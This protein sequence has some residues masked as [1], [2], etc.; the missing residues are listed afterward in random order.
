MAEIEHVTRDRVH[1][2]YHYETYVDAYEMCISRTRD[3]I[4]NQQTEMIPCNNNLLMSVLVCNITIII[5]I[6]SIVIHLC[7]FITSSQV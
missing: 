3:C 1:C 2:V 5:M 6:P 4:T 7:K